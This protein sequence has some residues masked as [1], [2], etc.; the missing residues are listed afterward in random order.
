[1]LTKRLKGTE[2]A[3][4][5]AR[6]GAKTLLLTHK[7]NTIGVLSCNPSI[8]GVGKG[9]VV[10]EIDALGGLMGKATDGNDNKKQK[11]F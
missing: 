8:G 11:K 2:A 1:M 5:S 4:A 6:T 10:K 7:L 3:A 9:H